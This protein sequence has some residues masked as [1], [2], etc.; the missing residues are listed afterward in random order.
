MPLVR[1]KLANFRYEKALWEKGY[2]VIGVDEVGRGA[3]AG[4]LYV[5]AVV[6]NF[7]KARYSVSR[8]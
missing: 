1:K 3:L 2:Y 8:F 7:T 6:F 5:G 4:P